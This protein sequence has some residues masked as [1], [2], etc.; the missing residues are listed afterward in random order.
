VKY[1]MIYCI[2]DFICVWKRC[3]ITIRVYDL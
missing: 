3:G 2:G 1:A